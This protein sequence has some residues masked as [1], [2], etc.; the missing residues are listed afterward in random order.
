MAHHRC[1]KCKQESDRRHKYYG[2]VFCESCIR[3]IR[4]FTPHTR[5][6][7]LFGSLWDRIVDFATSVF[8]GKAVK[9]VSLIEER[10]SH[11]RFKAMQARARSIPFNPEGGVP[12]QH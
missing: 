3:W 12:Q 1:T 11:S 2:G 7:S 9:R 4:G 6:R 5:G 10:A 8:Q